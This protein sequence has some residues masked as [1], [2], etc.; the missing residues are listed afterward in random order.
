MHL[1]RLDILRDAA[2]A[3]APPHQFSQC[4]VIVRAKTDLVMEALMR[5]VCRVELS[6]ESEWVPL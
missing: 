4:E 6:A 1:A 5:Q 2:L 3:D